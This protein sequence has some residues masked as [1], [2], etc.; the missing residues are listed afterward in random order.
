MSALQSVLPTRLAKSTAGHAGGAFALSWERSGGRLATA[1]ADKTVK[2]W[3]AGCHHLTTLQVGKPEGGTPPHEAGVWRQAFCFQPLG[4]AAL[5]LPGTCFEQSARNAGVAAALS[6]G[7]CSASLA[8]CR[9][10]DEDERVYCRA[11]WRE[12]WTWPGHAMATRA[13]LDCLPLFFS[14]CH[15]CS[16]CAW[17][18]A[19]LPEPA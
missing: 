15:S 10:A 12:C 4:T 5:L 18:N 2:L 8:I 6:D 11:C 9:A 13:A 14:V 3:D 17:L 1:G 19:S 7:P 16:M